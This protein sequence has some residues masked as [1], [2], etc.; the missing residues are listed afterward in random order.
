MEKEPKEMLK[1]YANSQ[2]FNSSTGMMDAMKEILRW[3]APN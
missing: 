2:K 3:P 1:A